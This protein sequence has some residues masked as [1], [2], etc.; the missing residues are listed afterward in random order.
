MTAAA[1]PMGATKRHAHRIENVS[2]VS[3]RGAALQIGEAP[4]EAP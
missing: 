1:G 4:A 2:P 3:A